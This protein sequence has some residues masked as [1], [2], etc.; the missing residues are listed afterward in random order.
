VFIKKIRYAEWIRLDDAGNLHV[1]IQ[2]PDCSAL[3]P[4]LRA[5]NLQFD[6][7]ELESRGEEVTFRPGTT[8]A[9]VH[10][11]LVQFDERNRN[12]S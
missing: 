4:F 1:D 6:C 11:A 10:A 8:V 7:K 12:V 2:L 3:L 5:C 9:Q